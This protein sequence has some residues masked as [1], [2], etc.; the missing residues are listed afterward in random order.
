MKILMVS[1][2][3]PPKINTGAEKFC[4]ELSTKLIQ[5]GLDVEVATHTNLKKFHGIKLH[6][7]HKIENK[8]LRKLFCDY[9]NQ[10]NVSVIGKILDDVNPDVVHFH[11]IYGISTQIISYVSKKYHVIVT[12]HDYWPFCFNSTMLRNSKICTINCNTCRF[13]MGSISRKIKRYHL[14]NAFLV[15]PSYFME[16]KLIYN[17]FT[18]VCTIHNAID[19]P[20]PGAINPK[21]FFYIGRLSSEKGVLFLIDCA[22]KLK[23]PV[24]IIGNGPLLPLISKKLTTSINSNVNVKGFVEKI[25]DE[26]KEGG[27]LIVPSIWPD[28]LPYVILEAM[29]FGVPII[30]SEI[31]GIPEMIDHGKTGLLF[32][33]GDEI[34]FE[35][36]L[37]YLL[38]NPQKIQEFGQN[39]IK[40]VE[41]DFNWEN[42]VN[43][44]FELY[45]RLI[46][47]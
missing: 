2:D 40:K 23:F 28:N 38:E 17:G 47:R 9:F 45:T 32:K 29:S 14:K 21:R 5:F 6:G 20:I 25:E 16:K 33:P 12:A 3:F 13:P 11:N 42:T 44:Y 10:K 34:D 35:K 24:D 31:G 41:N 37:R 39:A 1:S 26:Y 8:Y 7:L 30:G 18:N 4:Y 22:Q 15:A 27:A 36:Q 19:I 43:N 46:N